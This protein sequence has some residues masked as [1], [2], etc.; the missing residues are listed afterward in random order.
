MRLLKGYAKLFKK[1]Q[2]GKLRCLLRPLLLDECILELNNQ[3]NT[4]YYIQPDLISC[5]PG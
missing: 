3:Q 5:L 2:Y 1:K 4:T